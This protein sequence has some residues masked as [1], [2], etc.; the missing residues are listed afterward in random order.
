M[1]R[2]IQKSELG[3]GLTLSTLAPQ[4]AVLRQIAAQAIP[5]ALNMLTV[6]V[7]IFVITWYM[8][9]F[10]KEAVAAYG[11]ATRIEQVILLPTIGLN[12]AVLTLVGQNFGA[13]LAS[14]VQTAWRTCLAYGLGLMAIGGAVLYF[15]RGAAMRW[16]TADAT[17]VSHGTDYLGIAS[18]TLCAYPILFVTV[19]MLQ[20]LKKPAFGLWMGLYR[21]IVA[22]VIVFHLLG[23][24][25]GWQLWG[26]WWGICLVTWS[27]A[28]FTLWWGSRVMRQV[29]ADS[30]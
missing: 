21:Q 14:R 6:A 13:G 2:T 10:G 23:F 20:G 8:G 7:G 29:V 26:I 19:F 1:W 30:R 27:G 16:F 18:I 28:L 4:P 22:P 25:L 5:A 9:R 12:Y 17:V 24:V 11:I 15:A 3:S